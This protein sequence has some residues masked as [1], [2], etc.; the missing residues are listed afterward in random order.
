MK[1][2]ILAVSILAAG[3]GT[4]RAAETHIEHDG[5]HHQEQPE[6][7]EMH[8]CD[9]HHE[10]YAANW[11]KELDPALS[12]FIDT[13]YYN[14]NSDEGMEHLREEMPGFGHGHEE[15]RSR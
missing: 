2:L 10:T 14:E 11:L 5:T 3:P 8:E 1:I 15:D 12:V 4:L 9:G 6:I 13:L 7:H